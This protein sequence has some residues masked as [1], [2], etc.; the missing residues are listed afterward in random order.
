MRS[1]TGTKSGEPGLVTFSTKAMMDCFA[2]PSFHDGKG[3][4]AC[5]VTVVNAK[6]QMNAATIRAGLNAILRMPCIS[7]VN[8]PIRHTTFC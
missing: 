6:A 5:E 3:S 1:E 4:A 2:G 7:M 8:L